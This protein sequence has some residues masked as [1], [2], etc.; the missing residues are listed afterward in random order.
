MPQ[1][2]GG[3]PSAAWDREVENLVRSEGLP[4]GSARD[5][6]ILK[7]LK[8][9]DSRALA[10]LLMDGH[11]PAPKV[12]FQFALMLLDDADA[13][14]AIARAG[15]DS[16]LLPYRLVIKSRSARRRRSLDQNE[17]DR[18]P[19]KSASGLMPELRYAAAVE[20]IDQAVRATSHATRKRTV[21][22]VDVPRRRRKNKKSKR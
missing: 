4:R 5:R 3:V 15:L 9:G 7:W 11:V 13:D 17:S 8:R 2:K 20:L 12:R 22:D 14:A 18:V 19:D 16:D 21:R 10:G 1:D 6:V